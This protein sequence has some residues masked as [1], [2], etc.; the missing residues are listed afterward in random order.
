[1]SERNDCGPSLEQKEEVNIILVQSRSMVSTVLDLDLDWSMDV[2]LDLHTAPSKMMLIRWCAAPDLPHKKNEKK[3]IK[4]NELPLI[5]NYYYCDVC[6]DTGPPILSPIQEDYVQF[7]SYPRGLQQN[8]SREW[9]SNLFNFNRLTAT[10]FKLIFF[11]VVTVVLGVALN[12]AR[13]F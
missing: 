8:K 6:T 12:R 4:D 10:I 3:K 5:T 13:V 9:E 2:R 1:M 11:A 7:I